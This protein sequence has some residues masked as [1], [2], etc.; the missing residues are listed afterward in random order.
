LVI[1]ALAGLVI[2]SWMI[3]VVRR[4]IALPLGAI[5]K[6]LSGLAAGH[7]DVTVPGADRGDEIG[8]MAQAFDVFRR[9]ATELAKAHKAAEESHAIAESPAATP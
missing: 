6:A 9:N 7:T 5:T 2:V 4:R 3:L 1:G 8:A